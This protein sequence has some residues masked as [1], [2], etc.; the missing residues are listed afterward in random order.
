MITTPR[1]ILLIFALLPF[2]TFGLGP[3]G[4][5]PISKFVEVKGV[6]LQY[7]DWGGRGGVLLFIPGGCDTPYVFGDL[8]P[9]FV[10]RFR[11]FGLT[12]RGCGASDRPDTGYDMETQISDLVRFMDALN[13]QTA[14]LASHSMGGG[15]ITQFA[16]RHPQRVNKLIYFDTVYRYVAP[17][18]EEIIGA[19]IE[20]SVGGK[21]MDSV[22]LWK[23]TSKKW[24]LGAWS[25][26]M[27][28]NLKEIVK[29]LPDGRLQYRYPS[30]SGWRKEVTSDME[31]GLCFDT[32][33]SHPALMILAMDTD[34]DRAKQFDRATFQEL[35]PLIRQTEQKRREEIEAFR[36]NGPHVRIVEMRHTAHYC[37]VQKPNAVTR[38][39]NSFLSKAAK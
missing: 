23:R 33:I 25:P 22:Q 21:S 20:R 24:E 9:A 1:W 29:I 2:K 34:R 12:A 28:Q 5:L 36:A 6:R 35:Q 3:V 31:A 18:L 37:F 8:A 16:R 4:P 38:L 17:R 10:D 15:W 32:R 39:M 13:I 7:L 11:V 27:E 26:S 30:P 14:T 19:A